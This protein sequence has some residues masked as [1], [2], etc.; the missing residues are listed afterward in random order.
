MAQS[1]EATT[2]FTRLSGSDNLKRHEAILEEMRR[3]ETDKLLVV[4]RTYRYEFAQPIDDG[5]L[6]AADTTFGKIRASNWEP[7]VY[8][9]DSKDIGGSTRCWKAGEPAVLAKEKKSSIGVVP[10]L[11]LRGSGSKAKHRVLLYTPAP[12]PE[13]AGLNRGS[14]HDVRFVVRLL[15]Q[16]SEEALHAAGETLKDDELL[17]IQD[18][19][20]LFSKLES[21]SKAPASIEE[22]EQVEEQAPAAVGKR[23]RA[24]PT[25]H[26]S[27]VEVD[28]EPTPTASHSTA[29]RLQRHLQDE[30]EHEKEH[31]KD[32]KRLFIDLNDLKGRMSSL[33]HQ[34]EE[35]RK[36]RAAERDFIEKKLKKLK[37]KFTLSLQQQHLAMTP[38]PVPTTATFAT[39]AP[40]AVVP[41]P[42]PPLLPPGVPAGGGYYY[43]P[44]TT[45]QSASRPSG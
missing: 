8:A 33:E 30:K 45:P 17:K 3:L 37:D 12:S 14:K 27:P 39:V 42:P 36:D 18:E 26:Q 31:K 16:F 43:F 2:T 38:V 6:Y 41:A 34:F 20:W 10:V 9:Y 7:H 1:A 25:H 24:A 13:F 35:A 22:E 44:V 11:F 28:D 5:K 29:N 4:D 40:Q 19:A 15:D 21:K 23:T 32:L